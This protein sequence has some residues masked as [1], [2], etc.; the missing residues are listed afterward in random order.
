MEILHDSAGFGVVDRNMNFTGH[1]L[2][3]GV[4][5]H[6]AGH[7]VNAHIHLVARLNIVR[8]YDPAMEVR[9]GVFQEPGGERAAS[10]EVGKIRGVHADAF[11][12]ADAVTGDAVLLL[13]KGSALGYEGGIFVF[14]G[15]LECSPC[16]ERV[17]IEL[18]GVA[19]ELRCFGV[20]S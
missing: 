19:G 7:P 3:G 6:V 15:E 9:L 18:G 4:Y 20:M 11:V 14:V 2:G 10:A 13:K 16:G 17:G 5:V 8:V 12:P 1:G